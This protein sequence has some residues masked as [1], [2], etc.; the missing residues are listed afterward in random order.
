MA[1]QRERPG[2]RLRAL[3]G[4]RWPDDRPNRYSAE[5]V[6]PVTVR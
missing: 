6:L 4:G 2:A 3:I 1:L 5:A